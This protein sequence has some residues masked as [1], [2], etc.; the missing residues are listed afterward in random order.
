MKTPQYQ[1]THQA[2]APRSRREFIERIGGGFGAFALSAMPSLSANLLAPK[3][4]HFPARAKSVINL[5]M[6][7]G[8]SHLDTFDPK[9]ELIRL[10]GNTAPPSFANLQLQFTKTDEAPLMGSPFR[11]QKHGQSGIEV[12]ELFR[13]V[14]DH[15]DQM[16][17]VRSCHHEAFNTLFRAEHDEYG[18]GAAGLSEFGLM[19]PLR[20]GERI[21]KPALLRGDGLG[22]NKG[23][24]EYIRL[25]LSSPDLPGNYLA[26]QRQPAVEPDA[27]GWG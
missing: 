8:A 2:P 1:C 18:V 23:R 22:P 12:S 16:A 19:A 13:H 14:A 5:F 27:E 11:F 25:G 3:N 10:H 20:I 15:V 24:I 4:P 9:P 17:V 7:G 6:H 26:F 21:A